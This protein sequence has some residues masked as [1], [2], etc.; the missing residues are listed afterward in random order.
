MGAALSREARADAAPLP[1]TPS[2]NAHTGHGPAAGGDAAQQ[3][4]AAPVSDAQGGGDPAQRLLGSFV[5]AFVDSWHAGGL[6]VPAVE[7]AGTP[8]GTF[9]AAARLVALGDTHGDWAA[10]VKA[11]RLG[12]LVDG[13][14]R[15]SGGET[16]AVQARAADPFPLR[17]LFSPPQ[18][19]GDILDR[20]G[21]ELRLFYLFERLA[22]EAAAAGGALHVLNGNHESM[23]VSAAER[24]GRFRYATPAGLAEF[25]A[26]RRRQALGARLKA[27]C[28]LAAGSCD[29][30]PAAAS[31]E[32][33]AAPDGASAGRCAA[34]CPGCPLALRFL[35][36]HP[37]LLTVGS[38]AFAH[39][40][41]LKEHAQQGVHS[42]NAQGAEWLRGAGG[43]GG[44]APSFLGGT[45][46]LVWSRHYGSPDAQRCD[47]AELRAAL[48]A[49]PPGVARV[50]VGHTIQPPAAGV[51]AACGG[52]AVRVDVG[53]SAGCGG[54][55]PGVLEVLHDAQLFRIFAG[56][57][58]DAVREPLPVS[59]EPHPAQ[60]PGDAAGTAR[61]HAAG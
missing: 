44:H 57:G 19:V 1:P 28:G 8:R 25:D 6:A 60:P 13:E 17:L 51:N 52:A 35:A 11:L 48:A 2:A 12:G 38:T 53:M 36:P 9:P 37:F 54:H 15:W 59:P 61:P 43:P 16:V 4:K 5:D 26:W 46:A 20:G 49:L 18:Q 14:L 41:V 58:G 23:N 39:G 27:A 47:C 50:V 24:G 40:G 22:R 55:P 21:S 32:G 10:T 3:L 45:R 56:P 34:L 33:D 42:I 31:P 30:G 29:P 7:S